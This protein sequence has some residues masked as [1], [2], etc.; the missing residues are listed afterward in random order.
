MPRLSFFDYNIL[1]ATGPLWFTKYQGR[2]SFRTFHLFVIGFPSGSRLSLVSL[3]SAMVQQQDFIKYFLSTATQ[4]CS[5]CQIL[6]D[7]L[8]YRYRYFPKSPY[9]YRYFTKSPYWYRYFPEQP[10]RQRYQYFPEQP[11]RYRY[12]NFRMALSISI[13]IFS[14]FA[15]I[16]TIDINIQYSIHKSGE[17]NTKI[18]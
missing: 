3:P 1:V 5:I 4:G 7:S 2:T 12:R 9:R 6:I 14:K 11:Y 13:S 15:D 16:S 8:F 10:Y 18:G 17:K